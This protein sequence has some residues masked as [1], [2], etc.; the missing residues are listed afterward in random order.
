MPDA[1]FVI[2]VFDAEAKVVFIIYGL[3][4]SGKEVTHTAYYKEKWI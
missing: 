3:I 2:V 4:D 1:F